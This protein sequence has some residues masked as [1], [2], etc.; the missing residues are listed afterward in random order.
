MQ[1]LWSQDIIDT[2]TLKQGALKRAHQEDGFMWG[3]RFA[4][5][6]YIAPSISDLVA[7]CK[8]CF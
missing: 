2:E 3:S 8:S 6:K 1:L 5:M 4:I 7:L